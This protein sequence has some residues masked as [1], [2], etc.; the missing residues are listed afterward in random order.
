MTASGTTLA[1]SEGVDLGRRKALVEVT[2]AAGGLAIAAAAVPFVANLAP[3]ERAKAA[4]APV[5]ADLSKLAAGELMTVEWRGQP[6]WVLRRTGDMVRRLADIRDRLL[7][8]DSSRKQQPE[9]CRNATRS[10]R[11][12]VLVAV[13]ICTHLGCVPTFRKDVAPADLG[14]DWPGGFYCPCHGSKFDFAGRVYRNVPAPLNL[15]IPPHHYAG[16]TEVLIGEDRASG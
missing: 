7:D 16:P 5:R 3:S 10:I 8:P 15:V 6:V 2:A 13:G 4:G 11:P 9:Y 12:D 14:P 1:A